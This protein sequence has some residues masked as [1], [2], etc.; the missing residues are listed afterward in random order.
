MPENRMADEQRDFD[1]KWNQTIICCREGDR[2]HPFSVSNTKYGDDKQLRV[3]GQLWKYGMWSPQ[4]F[5]TTNLKLDYKFPKLGYINL[6]EIS[7]YLYRVPD[8]QYSAGMNAR[9]V[10]RF[11]PVYEEATFME[12]L[13]GTQKDVRKYTTMNI[14]NG[15][16]LDAI[17]N[18]IY[19]RPLRAVNDVF[20]AVRLAAA[21]SKNFCIAQ[22]AYITMPVLYYKT[23]VVGNFPLR[24]GTVHLSQHHLKEQLEKH[25]EVKLV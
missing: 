5:K 24:Q 19:I 13:E 11:T 6:G 12:H 15:E 9:V 14:H 8:R 25:F 3:L 16:M 1:Q 21:F 18:R 17:Y 7:I 4:I 22:K 2:A 23:K 20:N 10:K